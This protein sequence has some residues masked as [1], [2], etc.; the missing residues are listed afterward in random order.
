MKNFLVSFIVMA[1]FVLP[2]VAQADTLDDFKNILASKHFLIKYSIQLDLEDYNSNKREIGDFYK[3][4]EGVHVTSGSFNG[5]SK[6]TMNWFEAYD[7]NNFYV[8]ES[9]RINGELPKQTK[10]LIKNTEKMNPSSCQL[11]I[12][13]KFFELSK[14]DGK[15]FSAPEVDAVI[16][17]DITKYAIYKEVDDNLNYEGGRFNQAIK[18]LFNTKS[19]SELNQY[20][21]RRAGNG[22]DSDGFEYFDLK[23]ETGN[24]NQLNAIRYYFKDGIIKKIAIAGYYKNPETGQSSFGRE[25]ILVEEFNNKPDSKYFKLPKN[26]KCEKSLSE[27]AGSK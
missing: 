21:Y 12:G 27:I 4:K 19:D 26:F 18:A 6:F 2:N 15:Y 8:E 13:N 11:K 22:V 20:I 3:D 17:Y 14:M 10:D 7:G 9:A 1:I 24:A 25:I 16:S 23:A 5:Y